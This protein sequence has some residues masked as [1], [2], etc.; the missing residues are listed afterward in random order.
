MIHLKKLDISII[1]G[2]NML[3]KQLFITLGLLSIIANSE[4][5]E[6][7]LKP[8]DLNTVGMADILMLPQAIHDFTN[9]ELINGILDHTEQDL[10]K[11][12]KS[13]LTQ[14]QI[15][16]KYKQ[17]IDHLFLSDVKNSTYI[18]LLPLDIRNILNRMDV[19]N[20]PFLTLLAEALR[21]L[22]ANPEGYWYG[23][24]TFTGRAAVVHVAQPG[25][26]ETYKDRIEKMIADYKD[27]Q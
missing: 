9:Y 25:L 19:K 7:N 18:A 13:I 21:F 8:G 2:E 22:K 17:N 20:R 14:N 3:K 4:G 1:N 27:I 12:K 6:H 15:A 16:T 26:R 11:A 5:M 24:T 10:I 23:E